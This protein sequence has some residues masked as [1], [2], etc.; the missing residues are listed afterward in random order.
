MRKILFPFVNLGIG[1]AVCHTGLWR[2]L[3]N[4]GFKVQII[5]EKRKEEFFSHLACIDEL[6][7][8]DIDNLSQLQVIKTDIVICMYSWMELKEC[9]EIKILSRIRY[10]YAINVGGWFKRPYN[11]TLLLPDN[12]HITT[13][14]KMVL[15]ELGYSSYG[16]KY[17][18]STI[19]PVNDYINSYLTK[20]FDKKIIV[21]NPFASV[22]ERSM[23]EAQLVDVLSGLIH[24]TDC[25]FF[26]IGHSHELARLNIDMR[27]TSL[28]I[29]ESFWDTISLI[30]RADLVIS[31]D[32]SIVHISSAF[33]KKLVSI[34][35]SKNI[36]YN[37]KLQGNVIFAP[38]CTYS[39][40][41]I[42]NNT[43]ISFDADLVVKEILSMLSSPEK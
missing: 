14:Q 28:C 9:L 25:H 31:V 8:V 30:E 11:K 6:Y 2:K 1:D 18:I 37:S 23:N 21:I 5:A 15:K 3:K 27:N 39:K 35:Y 17:D 36:D 42:F 33:D 29:F 16:I 43:D 13:P 24:I 40:Q 12:F 19:K 20:H 41:I 10:S 22:A 34:F 32:T 4:E 7:I 38:N 26:I